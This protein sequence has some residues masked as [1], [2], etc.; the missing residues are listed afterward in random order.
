MVTTQSMTSSTGYLQ[1]KMIKMVEDL[2]FDYTGSVTSS[3]DSII[4][5][6]YGEENMDVS[7]LIKTK[8]GNSFIDINHHVDIL[9]TLHELPIN[10]TQG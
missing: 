1:R 4:Q 5:F 2:K 6:M 7:R 3:N 10:S 8:A 9:N